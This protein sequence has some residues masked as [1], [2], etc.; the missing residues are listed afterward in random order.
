MKKKEYIGDSVYVEVNDFG[1][2]ILT[3]EQGDGKAS[4]T[5]YLEPEVFR[6]L[7]EYVG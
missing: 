7:V 3:T 4:N 5:I 1:Q 2:I 6:A